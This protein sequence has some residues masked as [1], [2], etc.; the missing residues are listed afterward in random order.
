MAKR[1]APCTRA[2][3]HGASAGTASSPCPRVHTVQRGRGWVATRRRCGTVTTVCPTQSLHVVPGALRRRGAGRASRARA[4]VAGAAK[5]DGVRWRRVIR[6]FVMH[7]LHS[8]CIELPENR[9]ITS[10]RYTRTI[11]SMYLVYQVCSLAARFSTVLHATAPQRCWSVPP[12]EHTQNWAKTRASEDT[13]CLHRGTATRA[14]GL[15]P[16]A[17]RNDAP[18]GSPPHLV[19]E[20]ARRPCRPAQHGAQPQLPNPPRDVP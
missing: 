19:R 18:R 11:L 5:R 6:V 7:L 8:S 16:R 3:A 4:R 12:G 10:R 1:L 2:F 17:L 15:A 13:W 20:E 14:R 9:M